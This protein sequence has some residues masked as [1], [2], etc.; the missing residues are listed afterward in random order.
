MP[1]HLDRLWTR[2]SVTGELRL[3]NLSEPSGEP[4]RV[5]SRP[6]GLEDGANFSLPRP[7]VRWISSVTKEVRL[8]DLDSWPTARPLTHDAAVPGRTEP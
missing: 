6:T 7:S 5:I 8:W 1:D 3:W 4:L 2:D